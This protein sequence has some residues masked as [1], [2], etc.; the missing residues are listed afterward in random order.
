MKSFSERNPVPM[1]VTAIIVL[2]A[3]VVGA[4]SINDIKGFLGGQTY[5]AQFRDAAQLNPGTEV[6]V[7]GVKV[8]EVTDVSLTGLGTPEPHVRVDF[9]I[10]GDVR[11][12]EQ[13]GATVQ[14]KTLLGQR[15][16]ALAPAG[17]GEL[18]PGDTIPLARTATPLDVVDAVNGL[19]DTFGEIDTDALALAMSTLT[20]TLEETPEGFNASIDGLS[21]LSQTI[22]SRDEELRGLLEHAATVTSALAERDD[23]F[24]KLVEDG[25]RLLEEVRNRK[26]AIHELLVATSALSEELEGLVIDNSE[27]LRPALDNLDVVTQLLLANSENLEAT[28]TNMGPFVTAFSNVLGNGRWFDSYIDGLLQPY[29]VGEPPAPKEGE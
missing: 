23:E 20:D 9:R 22:A 17:G 3:A 19:A 15:Y 24:V 4:F 29:G 13:T 5:T 25:N 10:D 11:L 7:A 28:L 21:R 6:R 12:G 18:E 8:G 27:Q 16:V 26:D 2:V 1:G 14:L